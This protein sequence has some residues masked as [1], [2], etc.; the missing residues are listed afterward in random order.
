MPGI[1]RATALACLLLLWGC[2][3]AKPDALT[4][5]YVVQLAPPP[6][7]SYTGGVAGLAPTS[8]EATGAK[9]VD[10]ESPASRAYTDYL[11][12]QQAQLLAAMSA[13]LGRRAS[14]D[15]V[16][17][18]ALDGMVLQLTAAE[19]ARVAKL[20]GVVSVRADQANRPLATE[21]RG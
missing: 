20:P 9:R 10:L 21:P 7:V 16:Y 19:A 2:S 13:T 6:L 14:P 8:P 5:R 11:K 18:Y 4:Q 12:A 15:Y 17:Y 3:P 1:R